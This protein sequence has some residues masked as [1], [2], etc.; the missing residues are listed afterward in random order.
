LLG[1]N[2]QAVVDNIAFV[3]CFFYYP[4]QNKLLSYGFRFYAQL[5]LEG[6]TLKP[7]FIVT[8]THFYLKL[9]K[10]H[11]TLSNI[12]FPK[13]IIAVFNYHPS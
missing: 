4:Y 2:S 1:L 7:I 11:I 9:K 5:S 3:F 6:T 10:L 13:S 12:A 8:F